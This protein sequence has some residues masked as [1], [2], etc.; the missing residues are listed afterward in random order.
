MF[1]RR[2]DGIKAT[3]LD[4]ALN[5]CLGRER[6]A[7]HTKTGFHLNE[8]VTDLSGSSGLA[9]LRSP[10]IFDHVQTA[11]KELMKSSVTV[12][13]VAFL[14]CPGTLAAQENRIVAGPH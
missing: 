9:P 4:T 14:S 2:N 13:L 11:A 12:A 5:G 8:D 6:Y 1:V 7:F 10:L 3:G